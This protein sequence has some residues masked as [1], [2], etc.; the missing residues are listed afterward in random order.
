M[1]N[2]KTAA[3]TGRSPHPQ[4]LVY[5]MTRGQYAG[6]RDALIEARQVSKAPSDLEVSTAIKTEL[7]KTL[8]GTVERLVVVP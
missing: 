3:Y 2:I 6:W 4:G 7:S 1:H 5:T 8:R